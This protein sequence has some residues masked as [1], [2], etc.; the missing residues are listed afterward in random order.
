[1]WV[2][3]PIAAGSLAEFKSADPPIENRSAATIKLF[4][5]GLFSVQMFHEAANF[6]GL[7]R[8]TWS[9]Y[10]SRVSATF[11]TNKNREEK[12]RERLE[13]INKK[14]VRFV[15]ARPQVLLTAR[16]LFTSRVYRYD[17]IIKKKKRNETGMNRRLLLLVAVALQLTVDYHYDR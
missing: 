13:E 1:M 7:P 10:C 15:Q 9:K 12:H 5:G 11:A 17:E 16:R 2:R 14:I 6:F 4:V 3:W 8:P